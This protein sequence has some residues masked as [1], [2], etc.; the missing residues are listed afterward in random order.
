MIE[1]IQKAT[2]PLVGDSFEVT[3]PIEMRFNEMIAGV[4]SD[5][6]AVGIYGDDLALMARTARQI[7]AV[8]AKI[9]GAADLRVA[10]TDGFPSFDIRFD[11]DAISR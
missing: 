11:R 1:D 5:A 2:A 7:G 6:G 3:Q 4:R 8:I 9:P 10:Q